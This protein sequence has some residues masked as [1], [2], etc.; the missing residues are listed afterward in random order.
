MKLKELISTLSE[1][2]PE[3]EVNVI[4]N[5]QYRQFN[6]AHVDS[7]WPGQAELYRNRRSGPA[8]AR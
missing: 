8:L 1:F 3:A 6:R 2:N 4:A 7:Q 5:N